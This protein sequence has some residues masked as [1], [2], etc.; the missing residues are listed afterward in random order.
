LFGPFEQFRR[1]VKRC[2][3][4]KNQPRGCRRNFNAA[5]ADLFRT[6]MDDEFHVDFD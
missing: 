6:A 2:A 5:S 4:V 3:Y 1:I